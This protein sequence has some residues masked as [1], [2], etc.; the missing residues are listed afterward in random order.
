MLRKLKARQK[1]SCFIKKACNAADIYW[2]KNALEDV[3]G[4]ADR[5]E[6][7]LKPAEEQRSEHVLFCSNLQSQINEQFFSEVKAKLEWS[8]RCHRYMASSRQWV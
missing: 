1:Y 8:Q 7:T 2:Q 4:N 3:Q 6:R 5:V